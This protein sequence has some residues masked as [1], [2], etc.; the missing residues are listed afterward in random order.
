MW[1]VVGNFMMMLVP[2]MLVFAPVSFVLMP[3]M[4][5]IA[6]HWLQLHALALNHGMKL[7]LL[8]R[9]F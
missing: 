2:A 1:V 4:F 3:P 5:A 6:Y 8:L 9:S 7:F